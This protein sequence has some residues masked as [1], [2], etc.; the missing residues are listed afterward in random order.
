MNLFCAVWKPFR[1]K[2]F[3]QQTLVFK[4]CWSLILSWSFWGKDA[5]KELS[6]TDST[7]TSK[8]NWIMKEGKEAQVKL[9]AVS[10][11]MY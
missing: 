6:G 8:L 3:A 7:A 11:R 2:S 4:R 9:E 10:Y 5:Y 1:L